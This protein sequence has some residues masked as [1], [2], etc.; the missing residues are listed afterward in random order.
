MKTVTP[1]ICRCSAGLTKQCTCINVP[2]CLL[3]KI[4]VSLQVEDVMDKNGLWNQR[5]QHCRGHIIEAVLFIQIIIA[6]LRDNLC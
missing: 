1:A 4:I 2:I 5:R 3:I 6:L